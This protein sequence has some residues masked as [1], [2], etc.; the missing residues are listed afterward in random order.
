MTVTQG[1]QSAIVNYQS[2]SIGKGGAVT[3]V[4][5]NATAEILN[6]VTGSTSSVI[7]GTLTANGVVYLVNPNGIAI[8][9]S[10]VVNVGGGFVASTLAI[11]DDDFKKARKSFY[12]AGAS[13]GVTNAGLI[14]VGRGGYAAL[15]GGQVSN[16]GLIAVPLGQVA[17]GSGEQATLDV[18]GDGFLQV[19]VPTAGGGASPLVVEHRP[20][21]RA[22]LDGDPGCGDRGDRGPQCGEH[23]WQHQRPVDR[24]P[25]RQHPDRRR[26]RRI[27]GDLRVALDGERHRD[28]RRHRRHRRRARAWPGRASTP[29]ARPAAARSRPRAPAST[30]PGLTV[31][32]ANWLVD[33]FDLTVDAAAA[34]TIGANLA[35]TSVTLKTI[36]LRNQRA[37]QSE[38]RRRRR[39]LHRGADQLVE[40]QHP[41]A[42]RLSRDQHPGAGHHQRGRQADADH[43]RWRDGRRLRLRAQPVVGL[44]RQR[45]LH[46]RARLRPGADHQRAAL[47]AGLFDERAGRD[48]PLG[49]LRP[50][51]AA[52]RHRHDLRRGGGGRAVRRDLHRA[53][54]RHL[55]PDRHRDVL[56]NRRGCR[57]LLAGCGR[58]DP[59][60]RPGGRDG[61]RPDRRGGR[62]DQHGRAG[63][64]CGEWP[65]NGRLRLDDGDGGAERRGGVGCGR[66]GRRGGQRQRVGDQRLRQR[67]GEQ[68]RRGGERR[69]LRRNQP[70][71]AERRL[72]HRR[73]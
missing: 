1:S 68:Q 49:R 6:R 28:R 14:T 42:G 57:P 10:G 16:A 66:P 2:F 3:F 48:W 47:H 11:T 51:A 45:R 70:R 61:E 7:A 12:G 21:R 55:Q 24:R 65:R 29:R 9:Q 50:G 31:K 53:G 54:Q 63:G 13:T 69:R 32:A 35:T 60:P 4:Q 36:A 15:L 39:H 37:R 8:T 43:Q 62:S 34:A 30:S 67:G 18:S 5:P 40:R 72:R 27:G 33:P 58:D 20:D 17:L 44:R 25:G 56:D 46:R 41:D 64:R 71:D 38:L 73:R 22:G 26:P 52:Q 23:L 19:A 59:R